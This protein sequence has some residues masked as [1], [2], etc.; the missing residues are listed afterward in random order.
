MYR[1]RIGVFCC[2]LR[3]IIGLVISGSELVLHG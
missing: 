2:V 3:Y 1:T